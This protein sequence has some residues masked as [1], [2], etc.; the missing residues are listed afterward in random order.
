[1]RYYQEAS[2]QKNQQNQI[3]L[4]EQFSLSSGL[5]GETD[6]VMIQVP[7]SGSATVPTGKAAY[8]VDIASGGTAD[9]TKVQLY[10]CN[11]TAAQVFIP[12]SNGSLYNPQSNKCLDDTGWST[13][14]GT[15]LQIWDCTGNANHCVAS[16][17]TRFMTPIPLSRAARST[18]LPEGMLTA[19]GR[20]HVEFA[21]QRAV[22]P[23]TRTGSAE[24]TFS[25]QP[26]PFHRSCEKPFGSL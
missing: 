25:V 2:T 9:G 1:M 6:I 13:T 19:V 12:Q 7:V 10:D 23:M 18:M 24:L 26:L 3:F 20:V 21:A 11:N 22:I 8:N 16:V 15:Q 17:T 14:P 5:N 4:G